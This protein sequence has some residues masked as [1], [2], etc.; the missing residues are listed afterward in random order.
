META[1]KTLDD[2]ELSQA[3]KDNGLGTPA[4]R[5]QIIEVL[6]KREFIVRR[7]K[8]LEA[9]DKGI[10]LIETVHPEVKSPAM[11]G[12]WEAYLKRIERGE[13][14]LVPFLRGIEEYVREVVGKVG[15]EPRARRP[16]HAPEPDSA[17]A[18]SQTDELPLPPKKPRGGS[19]QDVLKSCFG[20]DAF[21][22]TQEE[23]C[24]TVASGRDVLLVMPTGSGKSLCYQLPGIV[25]GG[26]TIVVSPLIALMEDQVAKMKALGFAA[27]RIHSN[28]DRS[29]SR[30]VCLRYLNGE[31]DFLF[32]APERLRVRGFPEMLAKRKPCL[33]AIDEAHCISQWGHDFR[34]DYRTLGQH[35]PA[36]RPAPV[37]ALTATATPMVQRDIA[38]QLGLQ[39]PRHFI[40]GF[41]RDNIAVEVAKVPLTSRFTMAEQILAPEERRP[42]I[43]YT[44][45]RRDAETLALQL[46]RS[47]SSASYHAGLDG[48]RREKVQ[49]DFLAGK[50]DVIVATI[51]FGMGVDKP[52][53]RT[54][55]HTA[56]PGSVEGYYQEIGRAGRD[57]NPSRAILMQSY[58]DRRTHDFFF[59]RDYPEVSVLDSIY[60]LLTAEPQ[61]RDGILARSRMPE[62]VFDNALEKLWIHGGAVVD[63]ENNVSRG[64]PPY[65]QAYLA[66]REYKI[67]QFGKMLSWCESASCRMLAL[68]RYFGDTADSRRTCGVCDF[69]APDSSLAVSF[70]PASRREQEWIGRIMEPLKTNGGMST[71]RLFQQAVQDGGL[72]RR[73]FEDLLH[74]MARNGL[75]DVVDASF[76]KDGRTIEFRKVFLTEAG[77]EPDTVS[78]VV[79]PEEIEAVPRVKARAKAKQKRAKAGAFAGK[80]PT[81]EAALRAWRVSEAKSRSVPAFRILT[82]RSLQAIAES[83]PSSEAELLEVPGLGPKIVEKYGQRILRVLQTA[84]GAA[85][86]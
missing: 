37:I 59:E 49:Q 11:T 9:T 4:T 85:S 63:Y 82:D 26:T 25:L 5:A 54:V 60:A 58:S 67:A 41:R 38:R 83:L 35:L 27:E 42:A 48:K 44:P 81:V 12:Q 72:D 13:A 56:L 70:R 43:V 84:S 29:A 16:F 57:G 86:V 22:P 62:D 31:L 30:E 14:Q 74:A 39:M 18:A 40:Q 1:G 15:V 6:L 19:L 3:M 7:G 66:Q 68:V 75:V 71:G 64:A 20:F 8:S 36:L 80:A 17:E 47:F 28:R 52:D 46:S 65:G 2:K 34:P 24:R 61:P 53:I 76:E 77:M 10:R 21:R 79:I 50:L 23:V 32:I 55:I 45:T 69:C 51:A 73:G 33:I 78:A